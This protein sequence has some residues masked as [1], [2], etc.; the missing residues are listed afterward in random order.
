MDHFVDTRG[1]ISTIANRWGLNLV[2]SGIF[3]ADSGKSAKYLGTT[4]PVARIGRCCECTQRQLPSFHDRHTP[5]LN[6]NIAPLTAS[7]QFRDL[8]LMHLPLAI[9]S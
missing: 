6:V 8:A 3:E 4:P 7:S 1:N 2:D 5:S 9:R